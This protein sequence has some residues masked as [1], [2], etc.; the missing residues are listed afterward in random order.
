[1]G[2]GGMIGRE[3]EGPMARHEMECGRIQLGLLD[4]VGPAWVRE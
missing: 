1:M 3:S 4:V 2:I